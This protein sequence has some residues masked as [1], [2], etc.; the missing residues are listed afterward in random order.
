MGLDEIGARRWRITMFFQ[1]T[2]RENIE[3]RVVIDIR[4]SVASGDE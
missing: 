2:I 4:R 3:I 1:R